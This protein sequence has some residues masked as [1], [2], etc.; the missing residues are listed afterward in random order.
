MQVGKEGGREGRRVEGRW[1]RGLCGACRY[2]KREGE[3]RS[4][5]VLGRERGME[6][7]VL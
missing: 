4:T 6:G 1:K 7:G 5:V 2:G 3:E